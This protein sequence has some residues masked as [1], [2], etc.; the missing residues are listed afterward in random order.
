M[1][2]LSERFGWRLVRRARSLPRQPLCFSFARQCLRSCRI[3]SWATSPFG[4]GRWRQ[5]RRRFTGSIRRVIPDRLFVLEQNGLV[6]VMIND[7]MQPGAGAQPGPA[8]FA[9][10][11]FRQ[12]Q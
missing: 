5:A 12:C 8:C 4:C 3:S 11:E 10:V 7:V 6:K 9:A 1:R 2:L